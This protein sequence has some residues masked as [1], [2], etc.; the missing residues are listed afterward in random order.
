MDAERLGIPYEPGKPLIYPVNMPPMPPLPPIPVPPPKPRRQPPQGAPRSKGDQKGRTGGASQAGQKPMYPG[1]IALGLNK[2]AGKINK[3]R[4]RA[5]RAAKLRVKLAGMARAAVRSDAVLALTLAGVCFSQ[6]DE[7]DTMHSVGSYPSAL[8]CVQPDCPCSRKTR[9]MYCLHQLLIIACC[10]G[11][12][13]GAEAVAQSLLE[14]GS[15]EAA[16]AQLRR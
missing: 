10:G 2:Q 9:L 14:N 6:C 13:G 1:L 8:H 15:V 4:R 11:A 3:K 7:L 12:Y 16:Q 5:E